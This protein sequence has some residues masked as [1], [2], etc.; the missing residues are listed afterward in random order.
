MLDLSLQSYV[1]WKVKPVA[2]IK[3]AYGFRVV[4][5]YMDGSEKTQQKS[6]FPTKREA[7]KARDRTVAEL[8]NGNYIV[9]ANVPV[10][11]FMEYWLEQDIRAKAGSEET[12]DT[13]A[14]IA[15]NHIIP[16]IGGKRISEINAGDVQKLY[17]TKAEYSISV[18]RMV[19]TVVNVSFRYALNH[20]FIASNPAEGIRLPGKVEKKPYHAR[21]IDNQ[22]TLTLN[23]I[24]ILL[25]ASKDTPIHMQVLFNVLMGLRRS[26]INGLKYSDVDY[27]NRTLTVQR[28][29]G[30]K[31]KGRKGDFKPKTFTK[32]EI[33]LK[34]ESSYRELPIPDYVFE[35]ILEERKKYEKHKNR[36]KKEFQDL[37]YI[38]CSTYGRPRSKGYHF[39]HYKKLLADNGLPD[40]RWHDL[41]STFCTLLLKNDFSPKAVSK[42][43]GHAKEIITMDVYGDNK[44]IIED[45]IPE[46]A[47][48]ID[49]VLPEEQADETFRKELLEIVIDTSEYLGEAS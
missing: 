1:D 46:I 16:V 24:M 26:E 33:A 25:E 39:Q 14:R 40:I 9:Y 31:R 28:Q 7:E 8:Y 38:C 13:Y 11:E 41:R 43:M 12:Y 18:A 29:L 19:K 22:K 32:Q 37:D 5:K 20:K 30:K 34:S 49:E 2:R 47:G 23:Q 10:S 17:N 45:C 42:L 15:R 3:N 21:N 6:G 4:L 44:G 36:R 27:V 48:F 35:A